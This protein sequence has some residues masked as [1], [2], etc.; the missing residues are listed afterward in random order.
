MNHTTKTEITFQVI[1]LII[2]S[3]YIVKAFLQYFL[4]TKML[5]VII[6]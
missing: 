6:N 3:K 4:G 1:Q 5:I 2:L